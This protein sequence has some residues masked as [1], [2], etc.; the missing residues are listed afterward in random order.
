MAIIYTY[1]NLTQ[2]QGDEL[3][4]VTDVNN[5]NATR[6]VTIAEMSQALAGPGGCSSAVR[7]FIDV[8]GATL[9]D[10]QVC[11]NVEFKSSDNTVA[12]SGN[13]SGLDFVVDTSSFPYCENSF[14]SVQVDVTGG[15][16][17][18]FDAVGCTNTFTVQAGTGLELTGDAQAKSFQF[19]LDPASVGCTSAYNV[20]NADNGNVTTQQCGG[21][22]QISG[23]AISNTISTSASGSIIN[24][25]IGR[26]TSNLFGAIKLFNDSADNVTPSIVTGNSYAVQL[27]NLDQAYVTVP[28]NTSGM[29]SFFVE[30]T[31]SASQTMADGQYLTLEGTANQ[32]NVATT[33]APNPGAALAFSLADTAVQPGSYTSANITVDQK[34]RITSATSGSSGPGGSGETGMSPFPIYQGTAGRTTGTYAI[35]MV[36]DATFSANSAK[37]FVIEYEGTGELEIGVYSGSLS[38]QASG[39]LLSKGS[40]SNLDAQK[41]NEVD[42]SEPISFTAGENYVLYVAVPVDTSVL[43]GVGYSGTGDANLAMTAQAY[44]Q[45]TENNLQTQLNTVTGISASDK[46]ICA[47]IYA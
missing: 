27:N 29:N 41:I 15:A 45:I 9:W 28:V 24:I 33:L 21:S 22:F 17:V 18:T 7:G 37:V 10:T 47:H 14:S 25:E 36:A 43:G 13:A 6:Q 16:A 12:I 2:I 19:A 39:T 42:F 31:G 30:T 11:S 46:R 8:N 40:K 35:Q 32:I 3:L 34:G 26:A 1:P 20:V 44:E 23:N 4:V 5:K 38:N